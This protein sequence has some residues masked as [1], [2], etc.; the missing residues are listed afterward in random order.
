MLMASDSSGRMVLPAWPPTTITPE[1][2][3]VAASAGSAL[4]LA[5][6]CR[7][8]APSRPLTVMNF[9]ARTMSSVVTPTTWAGQLRR[10]QAHH[11]SAV[12]M[13]SMGVDGSTFMGSRPLDS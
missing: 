5:M 13:L 11:T 1:H 9:L 6:R 12:H 10:Q 3:S 4:T 7:Y 8:S 2:D